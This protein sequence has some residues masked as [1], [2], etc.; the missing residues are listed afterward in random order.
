[1]YV[2][3]IPVSK[4]PRRSEVAESLTPTRFFHVTDLPT[5][6]LN[7]LGWY[8]DA[9][10]RTRAEV[11]AEVA[12][13]CA[14]SAI[15]SEAGTTQARSIASLSRRPPILGRG[16]KQT[17]VARRLV[18]LL[19][20]RLAGRSPH[21]GYDRLQ[22]RSAGRTQPLAR[23]ARSSRFQARRSCSPA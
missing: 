11:A 1:M 14:P 19:C 5:F 23:A 4:N 16:F 8:V 3:R 18:P 9:T 22:P 17:Q 20:V 10:I 6:L 7:S 15:R 12:I 13:G 21:A 2:S